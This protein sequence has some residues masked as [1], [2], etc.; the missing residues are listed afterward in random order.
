M[1]NAARRYSCSVAPKRSRACVLKSPSRQQ[2]TSTVKSQLYQAC[3]QP[4]LARRRKIPVHQRVHPGR[5]V[6][7]GRELLRAYRTVPK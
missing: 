6:Q 4:R 1:Q 7:P 2:R 3:V 5:S